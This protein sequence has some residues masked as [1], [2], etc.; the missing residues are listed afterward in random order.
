MFL[1]WIL[2]SLLFH[3]APSEKKRNLHLPLTAFSPKGM[4]LQ[5][6]IHFPLQWTSWIL[7]CDKGA[8]GSAIIKDSSHKIKLSSDLIMRLWQSS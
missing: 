3:Y 5:G 8:S 4:K 1:A 7:V 6:K 2:Q